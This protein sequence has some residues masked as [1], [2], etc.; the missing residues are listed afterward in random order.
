M[1]LRKRKALRPAFCIP[2]L[3]ILE[4]DDVSRY[5]KSTLDTP[6]NGTIDDKNFR[7]LEQ[8]CEKSNFT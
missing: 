7:N 5:E 2:K 6:K 3:L 4:M 1:N 8:L